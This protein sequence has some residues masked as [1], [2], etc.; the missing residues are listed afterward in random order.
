MA[1]GQAEEEATVGPPAPDCRASVTGSACFSSLASDIRPSAY[2]APDTRKGA[3]TDRL[4]AVNDY[5]AT[6]QPRR[7]IRIVSI[8]HLVIVNDCVTVVLVPNLDAASYSPMC[9]LDV[10]LRPPATRAA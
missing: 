1:A 9:P 7:R 3:G 4:L 6:S 10:F 5:G 2:Y 8:A